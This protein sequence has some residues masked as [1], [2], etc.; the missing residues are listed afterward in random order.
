MHDEAEHKNQLHQASQ[1]LYQVGNDHWNTQKKKPSHAEIS[2]T[3]LRKRS[4]CAS[5]PIHTNP[6]KFSSINH[7]IT[8]E[9]L[10]PK[11]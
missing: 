10:T 4:Q 5:I 7:V 9:L 11:K 8:G 2:T 1:L 3:V 6:G